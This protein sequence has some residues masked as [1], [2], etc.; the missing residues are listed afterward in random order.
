MAQY[1]IR[2]LE[3]LSGIKAHTIRIWEKRY[4]LVEPDRTSTNIRLY[5]DNDL[6]K[7]LNVSVLNR[8]GF[9]ISLI[10]SLDEQE[11][12]EKI[13][14]ISRESSDY[15]SLIENLVM[16]MVEMNEEKISNLLSRTFMQLGFEDCIFKIISPFFDKIGILWQTGAINCAQEH[17]ASNLIRQKLIS[18]IDSLMPATNPE[19]KHFLLF[20]PE[21]ELHELGLLFYSYLLR[22][23]GHK[24]TYL[25]Q[26]VPV[27]D[28]LAAISVL[29]FDHLLTSV[30]TVYSGK[31]L[32]HYLEELS[33]CFP[34]K[35][36][37]VSGHQVETL[38]KGHP[39]NITLLYK[40]E[41]IF[42][43]LQ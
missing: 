6:K 22:K 41:D 31:E 28:M 27:K 39:G 37:F 38:E 10:A 23:K 13:Q 43:H 16:S 7:L 40:A 25:G 9:K 4:G 21:G 20:L 12:S 1:S 36:V 14:M 29:D 15:D 34:G 2:D 8:N 18:G 30:V 19:A 24:I 33:G 3:R 26:W 35:T 11:I 42:R 5:S 32:M 17:F